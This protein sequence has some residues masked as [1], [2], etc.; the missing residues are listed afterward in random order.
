MEELFHPAQPSS[1]PGP[2]I[3]QCALMDMWRIDTT[4]AKPPPTTRAALAADRLC[5]D[6]YGRHVALLGP[7]AE[8]QEVGADFFRMLGVNAR[9]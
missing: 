5:D 3:L 1:T 9:V 8:V 6:D 4:S 7:R 2:G